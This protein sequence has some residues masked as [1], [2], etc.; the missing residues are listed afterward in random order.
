MELGCSKEILT[1]LINFL[2]AK[3]LAIF[4][5]E[6]ECELRTGGADVVER[7]RKSC[8]SKLFIYR[9][10]NLRTS[11]DGETLNRFSNNQD[12]DHL[13]IWQWMKEW[14][15]IAVSSI[16]KKWEPNFIVKHKVDGKV[17]LLLCLLLSFYDMIPNQSDQQILYPYI[18]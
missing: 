4:S 14:S 10:I 16:N 1:P 18:S 5:H 6:D 12:I 3:F 13:I 2:P 7:S 8:Q 15:M 11:S 9:L 17:W